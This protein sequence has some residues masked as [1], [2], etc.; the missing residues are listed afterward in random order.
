MKRAR[1][2]SKFFYFYVWFVSIFILLIVAGLFVLHSF[3]VAYESTQPKSISQN[4]CDEYIKPVKITELKENYNLKLSDYETDENAKKAFS[5][6]ISGKELTVNYSSR[7]PKGSDQCFLV[8]SGDKS[9]MQIALSKNKF[10]GKFGM[11][12]YTVNEISLLDD[13]Y[14][15][16]NIV[17]PSNA[18]LKV[19]GRKLSKSDI[20]ESTLPEI[21]D[22]KFGEGTV[23]TCTAEINNLLNTDVEV[24]ASGTDFEVKKTG[25]G[26]TV[27][28]KF[29][30][31]FRK[32]IEDFAI[33]GAKAYAEYMQDNGSL[34]QIA[35]YIDTNS[36]FYKG[37]RGTIV[38][39]A[40][41]FN[42]SSYENLECLGFT[43]H[44]DEIYSCRVKFAHAMKQGV[45]I[46][47][48]YFDK[49]I[50]VRVNNGGKKIIDM[51]SN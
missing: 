12:G 49:R 40:L 39:F 10:K 11:T 7:L 21:K 5:K 26:F 18:Q 9:I 23:Y 14:K 17:F 31:D 47:H 15:S 29:D 42:S 27:S 36:D 24:K 38:R 34:G 4:I 25:D 16:V 30:E 22:V 19:N 32:D 3:L 1:R 37:I 13:V 46:Y 35:R 50:Y 43:K 41:S 6:L 33:D 51:Q 20:K 8:K 44:S 28:Q 45:K 2:K 48:D